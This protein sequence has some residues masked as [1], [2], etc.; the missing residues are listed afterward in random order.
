[1][2]EVP[3]LRSLTDAHNARMYAIDPLIPTASV[4]EPEVDDDRLLV[5]P[6][7]AAFMHRNQ[8]DPSSMLACWGALDQHS[9][10]EARVAGDDPIASMRGLLAA[11]KRE[12][13]GPTDTESSAAITWPSRDAVMVRPFLDSG[14]VPR[15]IVAARPARRPAA[16][17]QRGE[18]EIRRL[19][20]DDIDAAVRLAAAIVR[21]DAQ[22]GGV[23]DRACAADRI[24]EDLLRIASEPDEAAWLGVVDGEAVGLV[25]L[26]LPAEPWIAPMV[27]AD[28][29]AYLGYL[30]VVAGRRGNGVGSALVAHAHNVVDAAGY[31]VTLLHHAVLNPLSGPF[32]NQWGYRPLWTSWSVAPYT[33]LRGQ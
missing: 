2:H 22:F 14:L 17:R 31:D 33:D 24:R 19:D 13:T 18:V 27:R 12:L 1:M 7:A 11:W 32:W 21:W 16:P 30:S 29:V 9:L 25:T 5:A 15:A 3:R 26:D 4:P 6:D 20:P 8:V 10:I 28:R 23:T